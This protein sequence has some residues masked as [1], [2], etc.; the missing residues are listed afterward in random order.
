LNRHFPQLVLVLVATL[1]A[2]RVSVYYDIDGAPALIAFG[3][4]LGAV[5]LAIQFLSRKPPRGR[6]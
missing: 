5:G 3:F 2:L 4:L 1:F 6:D